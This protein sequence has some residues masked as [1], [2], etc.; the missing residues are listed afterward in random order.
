MLRNIGIV[1]NMAAAP[2]YAIGHWLNAIGHY[3]I[4]VT[5]FVG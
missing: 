5:P 1:V 2:H 3:A 4:G